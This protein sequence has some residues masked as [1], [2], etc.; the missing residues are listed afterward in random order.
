MCRTIQY[1]LD[2]K[3]AEFDFGVTN[4]GDLVG[5][6]PILK[7]CLSV[8][9]GFSRLGLKDSGIVKSSIMTTI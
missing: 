9:T 6:V 2:L 5:L 4:P 1:L 7:R 8:A 3:S